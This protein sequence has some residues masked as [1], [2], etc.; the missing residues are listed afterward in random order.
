MLTRL[1]A[2][3]TNNIIHQTSYNFGIYNSNIPKINSKDKFVEGFL[4]NVVH[5]LHSQLSTLNSAR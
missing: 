2:Y 1:I 5:L 4:Y 3:I